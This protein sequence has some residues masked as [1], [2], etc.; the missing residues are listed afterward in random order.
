MT[1]IYDDGE[2]DEWYDD[3]EQCEYDEEY[4][5]DCHLQA[6]PSTLGVTLSPIWYSTYATHATQSPPPAIDFNS[7]S[8]QEHP[9]PPLPTLLLPPSFSSSW[10]FSFS[11]LFSSS[12]LHPYF[13]PSFSPESKATVIL[14]EE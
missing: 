5:D 1:T 10:F 8:H 2:Y 13:S 9:P 6:L 3:D 11:S 4:D 14:T 12:P 7:L